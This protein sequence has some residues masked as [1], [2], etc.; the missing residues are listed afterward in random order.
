MCRSFHFSLFWGLPF[1]GNS[2]NV[3]VWQSKI[4]H[5]ANTFPKSSGQPTSF[6]RKGQP[7]PIEHISPTN[8]PSS[9]CPIGKLLHPILNHVINSPDQP[10]IREA[11]DGV[12]IFST[13]QVQDH[14]AG[15]HRRH[16]MPW[17]RSLGSKLQPSETM[18]ECGLLAL[19]GTIYSLGG[20]GMKKMPCQRKEVVGSKP[21]QA[22]QSIWGFPWM[23]VAPNGW[24]IREH[25]SLNGWCLGAAPCLETSM[26]N[27]SNPS[28]KGHHQGE[29]AGIHM[30]HGT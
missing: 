12:S 13:R 21:V 18:V 23:R 1:P 7:P 5:P 28:R 24:F 2:P 25:P 11:P 29:V 27:Q 10:S 20:L 4:H 19:G 14:W 30:A 9:G 3:S 8:S 16:L 22:I 6:Q 17:D 15:I 26:S